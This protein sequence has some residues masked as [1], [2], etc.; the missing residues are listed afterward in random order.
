VLLLGRD[1]TGVLFFEPTSGEI[2]RVTGGDLARH[3]FG[4]LG[5]SRLKGALLP[6]SPRG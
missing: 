3:D 2:R 4:A 5:Y 6:G 1:R